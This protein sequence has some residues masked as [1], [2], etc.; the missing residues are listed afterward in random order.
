MFPLF[1][2][3]IF[4]TFLKRKL[5][6]RFSDC[7]LNP[8]IIF[9]FTVTGILFVADSCCCCYVLNHGL[10]VQESWSYHKS[11]VG[12]LCTGIKIKLGSVYMKAGACTLSETAWYGM[13]AWLARF[14]LPG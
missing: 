5:V 12:R 1:K 3:E 9:R 6:N 13:V 10:V 8:K 7:N 14:C 2:T 11:N 4:L